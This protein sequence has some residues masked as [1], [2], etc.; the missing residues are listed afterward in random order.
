MDPSTES[1]RNS[2]RSY[3][4]VTGRPSAAEGCVSAATLEDLYL[5]YRPKRR[6][7]ATIAKERGLEPLAQEILS[8]EMKK[9]VLDRAA[10]FIDP[11]KGVEDAKAALS[12]AQD[13]IAE[14]K[15]YYTDEVLED[16]RAS[17]RKHT[18]NLTPAEVEEHLYRSVYYYWAYGCTTDEYYYLK[19]S[20][21]SP[22]EIKTYILTR[23]K[24]LYIDQL[25]REEDGIPCT[26]ACG[27]AFGEKGYDLEK[28]LAEADR[29]MY[30][31]KRKMKETT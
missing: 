28:V 22:E 21:K 25:N 1:P 15:K 24:V 13:I 10:D 3:E 17:V 8:R 4:D 23:E 19:L 11:E 9:A 27:F 29:A 7:R 20:E 31:N 30:E 16:L 6:T 18:E 12:G 5:P 2:R 26:V 14:K